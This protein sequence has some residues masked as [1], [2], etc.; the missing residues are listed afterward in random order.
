MHQIRF[1][2]KLRPRP[3]WGSLQRYPHPLAEF[4][5]PTSKGRERKERE[6]RGEG[7]EGGG[8]KEKGSEWREGTPQ[9][10]FT[11]IDTPALTIYTPLL[12]AHCCHF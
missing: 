6:R 3:R 10:F 9:I 7:K 1:R 8:K 4:K 5:G 11:W 12:C 2:L